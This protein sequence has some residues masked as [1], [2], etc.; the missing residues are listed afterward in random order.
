MIMQQRQ[1]HPRG[2]A[3]AIVMAKHGISG[4]K[5]VELTKRQVSEKQISTFKNGGRISQDALDLIERALPPEA[6]R[7]YLE[8]VHPAVAVEILA[9][10]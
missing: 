2:T 4:V 3:L 9:T 8:L 5:L 6:L 10:A 7:D 1:A